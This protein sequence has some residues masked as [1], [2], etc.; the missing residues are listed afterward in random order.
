[1]PIINHLKELDF[2]RILLLVLD[3]G[4]VSFLFYR[5]FL[6]LNRTRALQL[7]LGVILFMFASLL[8]RYLELTMLSW[9]ITNVSTYMVIGLLILMQP[10]L[11]RFMSGIGKHDIF[12]W[13]K[14]RQ[15]VPIDKV[16]EAA[17]RMA[18]ER[19][20]SLIVILRELKPQAIIDQSVIL[21]ADISAELIETIFSKK[22]PLHDGA[23]IIEGQKII[24]A[25]CYLPLSNSRKLKKTHGARHR[26]A[27]GISEESDAIV[28]VTSEESGNITIQV[29][30]EILIPRNRNWENILE[31]LLSQDSARLKRKELHT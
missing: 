22:S 17:R 31:E 24:A 19:I 9:V 7:L 14:P 18:R 26:A 8:A 15:S 21:N 30:G 23:I 4:L 10:E 25:S 13:L 2:Q 1:M 20:G 12:F 3:I 28:L 11:R 29:N 5:I 16:A 27:L 6:L